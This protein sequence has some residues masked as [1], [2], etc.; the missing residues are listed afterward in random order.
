PSS[1]GPVSSSRSSSPDLVPNS[2]RASSPDL[3][4]GPREPAPLRAAEVKVREPAKV[5]RAV[6]SLPERF[7]GR[8]RVRGP[9][10]RA[11]DDAVLQRFGRAARE[12]IVAR[13]PEE[14]AVDLRNNSINAMVA[15][16]LE[17]I[18]AYLHIATE[19]ALR[20]VDGWR[21][22]GRAS[23]DGSLAQFLKTV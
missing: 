15:Y 22:L 18:E 12:D 13:M 5:V 16:E 4:W 9:V 14:Y 6:P 10:L 2:G 1:P 23:A 19:V 20:E 3:S 8:F 17:A 21:G 7:R 11:V